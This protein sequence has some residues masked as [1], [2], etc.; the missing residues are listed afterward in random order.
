MESLSLRSD[1]LKAMAKETCSVTIVANMD[2]LQGIAHILSSQRVMERAKGYRREM[3]KER[4]RVTS[5]GKPDHATFADKRATFRQIAR[6]KAKAKATS[7]GV[8][9][10]KV[11][12]EAK[13]LTRLITAMRPKLCQ[14]LTLVEFG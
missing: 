7:N 12:G 1:K 2:T 3:I 6:A 10:A 13:V 5:I 8:G 11:I 4:A 14:K 9:K